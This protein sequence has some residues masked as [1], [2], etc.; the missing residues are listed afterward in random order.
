MFCQ[1]I[2]IIINNFFYNKVQMPSV[3]L[4]FLHSY[5][6]CWKC[7]FDTDINIEWKRITTMMENNQLFIKKYY[8]SKHTSWEKKNVFVIFLL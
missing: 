7:D 6:Y 4:S 1:D 2:F 3:M 8:I 5:D